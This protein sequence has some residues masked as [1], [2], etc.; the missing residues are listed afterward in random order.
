MTTSPDG[1]LTV[2]V[3]Y[4][5]FISHTIIV[6]ADNEWPLIS[7]YT[8]HCVSNI[9]D[10]LRLQIKPSAMTGPINC[11]PNDR[12]EALRSINR[13]IIDINDGCWSCQLSHHYSVIESFGSFLWTDNT[14]IGSLATYRGKVYCLVTLIHT[15]TQLNG[16]LLQSELRRLPKSFAVVL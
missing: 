4:M 13:S 3:Q 10:L 14:I 2:T 12:L 1:R 8:L 15:Y 9:A 11:E 6:R 7:Q 5:P 16:Q